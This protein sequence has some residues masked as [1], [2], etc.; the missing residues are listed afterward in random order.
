MTVIEPPA[1]SVMGSPVACACHRSTALVPCWTD[2]VHMAAG[3]RSGCTAVSQCYY[4]LPGPVL[5]TYIFLLLHSAHACGVVILLAALDCVDLE[6]SWE[7]VEG[8]LG[9]TPWTVALVSTH[10]NSLLAVRQILTCVEHATLGGN[11][12]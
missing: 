5:G 11:W 7:S 1:S 3:H 9:V 8:F 10:C 2:I 6:L 12:Y 4:F